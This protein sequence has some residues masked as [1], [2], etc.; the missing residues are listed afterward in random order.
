MANSGGVWQ[1]AIFGFSGLIITDD[2]IKINPRL[3][4]NW[5]NMKFKIKYQKN[6]LKFKVSNNAVEVS[7]FPQDSQKDFEITIA[8]KL[9]SIT[10]F[11]TIR[12]NIKKK[13]YTGMKIRYVMKKENLVSANESTPIKLISHLLTVNR[14]STIPIIGSNNIFL[15]IISETDILRAVEI[16]RYSKL[17]AKDLMNTNAVTIKENDEIETAI[18]IFTDTSYRMLPVVKNKKLTGIVTRNEVLTACIG[19]YY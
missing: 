2:S 3:P 8:G 18:Q 5:K 16:G 10:P 4:N 14:I 17:K 15:G 13:E 11:K 6:F 19:E 1:A 9:Y 7:Y 12:A